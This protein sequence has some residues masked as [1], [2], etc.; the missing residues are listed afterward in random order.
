M[1]IR[2]PRQSA[3][4]KDKTDLPVAVGFGVSTP[5]QAAEIAK[6]ADAVVVG[7]AI[8]REI[9]EG[10]TVAGTPKKSLVKDV[11]SFVKKLGNGVKRARK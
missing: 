11:L 7:S 10:L 9:V 8:V 1:P 5:E 3:R 2:S 4:I 6:A